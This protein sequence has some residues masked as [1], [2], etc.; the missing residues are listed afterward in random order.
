ME[1]R[2]N[3]VTVKRYDASDY[4]RWNAFVKEAKNELFMFDRNYMDYHSDRFRDHSLMFFKEDELVAVF[5]A[6]EKDGVLL[7]HEG[8]TYGGMITNNAMRQA[9]ML[10]CF[11]VLK[12]HCMEQSID[13]VLYKTIPAFYHKEPAEEDT[14]AL[15][16]YGADIEK[17][18]AATLLDLSRPVEMSKLRRR[19][20]N[21]AQK[22]NVTVSLDDSPGAYDYFLHM[23]NEVLEKY[24]GARAVHTGE[25]M[26]LLHSRF[27]NNIHLF[28]AKQNGELLGGSVIYSYDNVI[29]TQYLCANDKARDI[30]A[31]D[32]VIGELIKKYQGSRRWLDFGKSTENGGH[33]L[34]MG[35]IHQ[36]EG[37]GGRTNVY[38]TWKWNLS[39]G[40][41]KIVC[42]AFFFSQNGNKR[43]RAA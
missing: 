9:M 37:F 4:Q 25:E 2:K 29:H 26:Y 36:K 15:F 39:W 18:E 34:N 1:I 31:L 7:S 30:G 22:E 20:I 41:K 8:L 11:A 21:K 32:A 42:S 6:N 24:H 33:L 13:S 38:S 16:F 27:P 35:L 40:G 23:Q 3:N 10:D 43:G 28:T 12:E 19:Q 17:I 5:P 14:Y